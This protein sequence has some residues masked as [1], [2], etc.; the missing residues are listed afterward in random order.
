VGKSVLTYPKVHSEEE[1]IHTVSTGMSLARLGDGELKLILGGSALREPANSD[2][3]AELRSVVRRPTPGCIVGIPTL[4][5]SGPK[6][7]NWRKHADRFCSVLH[8][9][10]QYYSAFVSRPDSA[11]WIRTVEYAKSVERLWHG[12]RVTV[13]CEPSGFMLRTVGRTAKHLAHI[14][15]PRSGAYAHI[16]WIAKR[17]IRT[18]PDVVI[19]AA[20][21]TATCLAVRFAREGLQAIDLG[22]AGRFIYQMLWPK[23]YDAI[24]SQAP[25]EA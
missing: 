22:S 7:E 11:P 8:P 9:D 21:P 12:K 19:M 10:I 14:E 3:G 17:V 4:N 13:V 15:C 18:A 6:Y 23:E 20:G 5:I 24:N 16:D 2:L 25:D 1:T